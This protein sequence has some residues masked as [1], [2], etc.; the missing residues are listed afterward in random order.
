MKGDIEGNENPSDD[1]TNK[2]FL[3]GDID[4]VSLF[5]DFT[6]TESVANYSVG[7][8]HF[9]ISSFADDGCSPNRKRDLPETKIILDFDDCKRQ[10]PLLSIR[11]KAEETPSLPSPPTSATMQHESFISADTLSLDFEIVLRSDLYTENKYYT[12]AKLAT[13]GKELNT[14]KDRNRTTR[15]E[16]LKAYFNARDGELKENLKNTFREYSNNTG[17]LGIEIFLKDDENP[18]INNITMILK[19][20]KKLTR[21][22]TNVCESGYEQCQILELSEVEAK[23]IYEKLYPKAMMI[24]TK[25]DNYI[26]RIDDIIDRIQKDHGMLVS[27]RQKMEINLCRFALIHDLLK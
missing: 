19:G 13:I 11:E 6:T 4:N 5:G 7:E 1:D 23:C 26:Q 15:L 12:A 21:P 22:R 10:R 16:K 2:S 14:G 18:D 27:D 3:K 25:N 8:D 17:I 9:D 20:G 24:E